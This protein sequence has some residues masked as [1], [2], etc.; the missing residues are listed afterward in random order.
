MRRSYWPAKQGDQV[1]WARNLHTVISDE[2]A[3]YGVP[4]ALVTQLGQACT[5]A[6]SAFQRANDPLT[7]TRPSVAALRH[8]LD[9]VRVQARNI[10]SIIQGT[11]IV[12]DEMKIA[13]GIT[14]RKTTRTPK[15]P[16]QSK[17]FIQLVKVDGRTATF[18]LRQTRAKR[19]RPADVAGATV[20]LSQPTA[21]GAA[22]RA[23]GDGWQF[24]TNTTKTTFD[25]TFPPSE[26]GDTYYVTAFWSNTRDESGPAADAVRV[27][28]P[29]GEAMPAVAAASASAATASRRRAA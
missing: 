21:A 3:G 11:A 28:L 5:N 9:V 2:S 19:G 7:R 23:S 10:V 26:T 12:S 22:P 4:A 18:E 27:N 17:P 13:V 14:V 1:S 15:P 29:A 8:A 6:E 20:F 24:A 25:L 16:P